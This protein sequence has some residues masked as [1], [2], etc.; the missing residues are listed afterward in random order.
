[1]REVWI[2]YVRE[3]RCALR[4]RNLVVSSLL[5]PLILYPLMLWLLS[6]AL[7][8]SEGQEERNPP[9]IAVVGA[10][11]A[12]L[13]SALRED[14]RFELERVDTDPAAGVGAGD[15]DG[16]VI[17]VPLEVPRLEGD[18]K[19]ELVFDSSRSRSASAKEHVRARLLDY[20]SERLGAWLEARGTS[21][22]PFEIE[23]RNLATDREMGWFI[24]SLTVP[25]TM[26]VMVG[27]GATYPA[28]DTIAGERERSTWETSLTLG[29]S[30]F[31]LAFAKY[32]YVATIAASAG[33][34]N[35]IGI[36]LSLY[37]LASSLLEGAGTLELAI[38]WSALPIVVICDL[39][40]AAMVAALMLVPVMFA[41]TFREGQSSTA[42]VTML[43]VLPVVAATMPAGEVGLAF[44]LVPAANVLLV[45]SQVLQGIV[46]PGFIALTLVSCL[47]L[48]LAVLLV[49]TAMLRR[50]ALRMRGAR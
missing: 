24:V 50:E 46:R 39:V 48:T 38:P 20:R 49:S 44:A 31:S 10:I 36:T 14:E 27:L 23:P 21:A 22:T 18:A 28:I 17:G 41:R 25:A 43:L 29:C 45:F 37:G 6:L 30:R 13:E 12:A 8:L 26:L 2:L 4:E 11:P 32:L 35:V 47:A 34:L 5:L 3:L 15:W 40:L 19:V 9:R 33:L 16:A 7:T 42:P 1:M